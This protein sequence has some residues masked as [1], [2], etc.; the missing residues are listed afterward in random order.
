ML[1]AKKGRNEEEEEELV[2]CSEY[3]PCM[4]NY[5]RL[6]GQT[7]HERRQEMIEAFNADPIMNEETGEVTPNP[8]F[9]FILSTYELH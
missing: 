6:D 1:E 8:N 9:L 7:D 3:S 4:F 5:F 2:K